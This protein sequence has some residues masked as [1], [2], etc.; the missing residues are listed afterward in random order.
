MSFKCRSRRRPMGP[1][2]S[3]LR[4]E[5]IGLCLALFAA[6]AAGSA[7]FDVKPEEGVLHRLLGSR[8]A[9]F[10]L[11]P[12]QA[13]G[14]QERFRISSA[15]GRIKVEGSTPSALL[16]GVNWY[17]KY[18]AQVQMSPNGDAPWHRCAPGRCLPRRSKSKPPT[19]TAMR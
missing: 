9:Q 17:L 4:L 2:C 8:A 5:V 13:R 19:P 3:R 1:L 7:A 12:M 18:V 10:E 6:Q 15:D 16:F 11:S 14:G